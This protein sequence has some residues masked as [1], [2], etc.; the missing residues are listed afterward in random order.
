MTIPGVGRKTGNVVRSVAFGLPGL[1]VDTHVLRLSRRLGLTEG[2][3]AAEQQD[4]VKVELR[5]NSLVPAA[6]RGAFSLRMILHGGRPSSCPKAPRAVAAPGRFL[7]LPGRLTDS[8]PTAI[9]GLLSAAIAVPAEIG[10]PALTLTVEPVPATWFQKSR[11]W[12]PPPGRLAQCRPSGRHW[13]FRAEP[14]VSIAAQWCYSRVLLR[15][16]H[17]GHGDETLGVTGRRGGGRGRGGGKR[18]RCFLQRA[19]SPPR[20][21]SSCGC[22]RA[23]AAWRRGRARRAR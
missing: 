14:L 21:R 4:A 2:M 5:L 18:G 19:G 10:A 16:Y 12:D 6:E 8:P 11:R 20:P 9:Y 22:A 15:C 3:T 17:R 7:P 23:C 13:C 1:P